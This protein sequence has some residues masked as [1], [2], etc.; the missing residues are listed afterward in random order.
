MAGIDDL[1]ARAAELERRRDTAPDEV[2]ARRAADELH[3]LMDDVDNVS[4]L[5]P[6]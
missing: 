1:R 6:P 4:E 2:T 3:Q 5:P